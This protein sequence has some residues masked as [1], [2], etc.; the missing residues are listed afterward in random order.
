MRAESPQSRID[1]EHSLAFTFD[2]RA[3]TGHPGDTL[4]SALLANEVRTVGRSLYLGRPRGIFS[5]GVEEPNALVELD[6]GTHV[7]PM[8]RATSVELYDG[9][10]ARSLAGKGRLSGGPDGSR[11]DKTH[12][13]CDVLVVG[14]GAAGLSAAHAAGATG[15]RVILLDEQ[16]E[17]G[18]GLLDADARV[19][20]APAEDWRRAIADRLHAARE[21]TVLPR[22]TALGIYDGGYVVAAQR[23]TEHLPPASAPEISRQRLWHIRAR[24][25]VLATGA[26]ERPIVFA[27]ND[28]PGVMLAGAAQ[29]YANRYAV[30]PGRRAVVF[31]TNDTAYAAAEDLLARG[32]ELAAVVDGRPHGPVEATRR[33][34]ACGT[35]VLEGAGVVSTVGE[36][37]LAG[38][39]IRAI[40][41]LGHPTGA[42]DQFGCDLLAVSGGW[43]PTLHLYVQAGGTLRYDR[44]IAA[45][46]ADGPVDGVSVTGAAAGTFSLPAAIAH[47]ATVGHAAATGTALD[48]GLVDPADLGPVAPLWAVAPEQGRA[49]ANHFV[50]LHRDATVAD[51]HRGID[52]GLR[53]LEHLKRF[54]T[55]G[56]GPDQGKTANLNAMGIVAHLLDRP[57]A[58]WAPTTYRP[59]YVPVPF[60]A[61]AGR[62]RGAL[63]HVTQTT[64]MDG[65]HR[66]CGAEFEYNGQWLRPWF[67]PRAG[68]DMDAAVRRECLAV[69]G[70]VGIMD[71]STLGKIDVRGPDAGEFL[72]RVYT[73]LMS[74]LPAG[75]CRYGV[76]CGLDGMI[77]DDGVV[78]RLAEDHYVTT[79]TT[80]NAPAVMAWL[81]QWQQVEWP[82]LDVR[83]TS[84]TDHWATV[85]LAGPRSRAVLAQLAPELAVDAGSM[86]FLA[87]RE[88]HV[89]GVPSRVCRVSFSGE[90]AFEIHCPAR[91]ALGLWEAAMEAGRD[92][93]ITPY[94]T[95]ALTVLRAEKGLILVG[96]D[97]DS[98]VTPADAGLDWLVSKKK[99][100]FVGRR[101][102]RRPHL[103]RDDRRQLVGLLPEDPRLQIPAGAQLLGE[104]DGVPHTA[105]HVTSSYDSPT[106]GR[107]FALAL[108]DDGRGRMGETV[109]LRFAGQ[110]A[111]ATVT[112]TV[113]YDPED[114]RRDGDPAQPA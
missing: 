90:L 109:H 27:D 61:L 101:S 96:Q 23:R 103:L 31:T 95:E 48:P 14:G 64:P 108:L 50:D 12:A 107:T 82:E 57:V 7:Q 79:T 106:L 35:T 87:L 25:I 78:M 102:Q 105:G 89:A 38:V 21:I 63:H 86:P 42:L 81:E 94:G 18:G 56:T 41:A 10:R 111:A 110:T 13:T 113:F 22:T 85:V 65:W 43:V 104:R 99:D 19:D 33:L 26:I 92:E 68:E 49:W 4:A 71:A 77:F 17:L 6:L 83:L 98:T 39:R 16:P 1:R 36:P 67:Y 47:A 88:A 72:D 46:V 114:S 74:T 60:A 34:R 5:A 9:L 51:L 73:N 55:I 2:G 112:Q 8:V 91:F 69:R 54:T 70:G 45:H 97:T 100:F 3:L 80:G 15:A 53:S 52:A 75:R 59:P 58:S 20:G 28:R 62:D 66:E 37:E 84:V 30:A 93:D 44:A 29:A 32:V 40:D 24:H 11:Y 76:L